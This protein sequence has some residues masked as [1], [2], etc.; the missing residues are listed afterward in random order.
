MRGIDSGGE[1]EGSDIVGTCSCE[2]LMSIDEVFC[3]DLMLV[4]VR[5]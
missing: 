1:G 2:R 4:R 5:I 3:W